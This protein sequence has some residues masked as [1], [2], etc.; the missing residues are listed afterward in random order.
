LETNV[1][2]RPFDNSFW[3]TRLRIFLL[4]R[5]P[6]AKSLVRGE[7]AT[8]IFTVLYSAVFG[9]ILRPVIFLNEALPKSLFRRLGNDRPSHERVT[10]VEIFLYVC[11]V[12]S[13]PS[14]HFFTPLFFC[15]F[16][17]S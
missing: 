5:V 4:V 12:P 15:I 2:L 16:I 6:C 14:C 8:R 11:R 1:P 13:S 10:P 3:K 17:I 7:V 9:Q